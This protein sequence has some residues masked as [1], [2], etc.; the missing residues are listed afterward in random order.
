MKVLTP[1]EST[2][3]PMVKL[4]LHATGK[5]NQLGFT[6]IELLAVLFLISLITGLATISLHSLDG[7]QRDNQYYLI[8]RTLLHVKEI[9]TIEGNHYGIQ[10]F[11][12]TE[13][14]KL[15][16]IVTHITNNQWVTSSKS[17]EVNL[18]NAQV[19]LA[20]NNTPVIIPN[21]NH[22]QNKETPLNPQ[23]VFY[24]DGTLTPFSLSIT[25]PKNHWS[26]KGDLL[27]NLQKEAFN[28]P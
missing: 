16:I 2:I 4:A 22:S 18:S 11:K 12:D 9:A 26:L 8:E 13:K 6:L 14:Q 20:I 5:K 19:A 23:M 17:H 3:K 7:R 28:S 15:R 10:F 21:L 24:A 1:I 25:Q 27:G